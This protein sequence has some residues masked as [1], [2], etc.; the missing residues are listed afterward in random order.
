M[1]K[2]LTI[3]LTFSLASTGIAMPLL[4]YAQTAATNPAAV[5]TSSQF[6]SDGLFGCNQTGA[7]ASSVG[8]FS[9]SGVYVP[10]SDAA[11]ELNTGYLVYLACSLRPLVSALSQSATAAMTKKILT[12]L[13]TGNNG[14]PQ[15]SVNINNENNA[16][17]DNAAI[18]AIPAVVA[19]MSSEMQGPIQ[20][21]LARTYAANTQKP[22]SAL[23]CPYSASAQA[24]NIWISLAAIGT[25]SCDALINYNNAY[26]QV[27]AIG[28]NAV[29]NNL[30]QLQ[31][32]QGVYPVTQTDA[33]GNVNVVTPGAIVLNQAQQALQ[34]GL[35]KTENANDIGQMVTALFAGIGAQAVS[36]AQGLAGISQ[37]SNGQPAYIDQV[38]AAASAGVKNSVVNTA[39]TVLKSVITMLTNYKNSLTTIANTLL[40][41]ISQLHAAESQCWATII[42][43]VCVPGSST[44]VNGS[45]TCTAANLN[46]TTTTS[47]TTNTNTTPAPTAATL[48]IATTT[49]GVAFPFSNA[50]VQ[51]QIASLATQ[52]ASGIASTQASL[53]AVNALVAGVTNTTSQD[54]QSLAIQQL[55]QLTASNSFPQPQSIQTAQQQASGIA[56]TM[57]T[58]I[59]T[60]VS[61][62]QGIDSNSQPTIPWDGTVSANTVGWCNYNNIPT[63]LAWQTLWKQ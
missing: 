25:P 3:V 38:V 1:R 36:S 20:T 33:Q 46:P 37:S 5:A 49:N 4:A 22:T 11:V 9:A 6:A 35:L 50:V 18:P 8:A 53:T 55:D 34:S 43:D 62:W 2:L 56:T 63:L 16:A 51:S 30:T 19:A 54:A 44:Y 10:V 27:M 58:L 32:G 47:P 14:G 61:N 59:N 29:Q 28:A 52:T 17:R 60:T 15:F 23:T 39:L 12:A 48:K 45:L 41:T 42:T 21:A 13:N 31:W 57:Q 40:Q 26:E 7:A 24:G